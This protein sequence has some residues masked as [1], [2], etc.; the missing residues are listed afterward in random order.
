EPAPKVVEHQQRDPGAGGELEQNVEIVTPWH[1][2]SAR[3]EEWVIQVVQTPE[4][5]R[6]AEQ[7]CPGRADPPVVAEEDNAGPQRRRAEKD[8]G[9][10]SRPEEMLELVDRDV[11]PDRGEEHQRQVAPPP[12][13]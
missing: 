2:R 8:Y 7:R 3:A 6:T 5:E 13:G 11:R 1:P 9:R 4:H 10:Q 12:R